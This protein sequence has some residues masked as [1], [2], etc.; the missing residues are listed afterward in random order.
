MRH[1][2]RMPNVPTPARRPSK[3]TIPPHAHPLGRAC[4]A[5]MRDTGTTYQEL[6]HHAGVLP[7]TIKS[8]R[9]EKIGSIRTYE[10]L[11]GA[12]GFRLIPCPPLDSLPPDVREKLDEISLHFRSDDEILAAA[13]ATFADAPTRRIGDGGPPAPRVNYKSPDQRFNERWGV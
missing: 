11:L 5:L 4:F 6:S 10:A 2:P 9:C 1:H 13:I 3:I 8:L 12:F 7:S